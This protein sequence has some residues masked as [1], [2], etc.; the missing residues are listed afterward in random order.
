MGATAVGLTA[1]GS[2][3]TPS[4]YPIKHVVVIFQENNSFDHLLG[5]LCVDE[6]NRCDGTTVGKLSN[7]QSIPLKLGGDIVPAIAHEVNT[8]VT[9]IH[10]GAMDGWDKIPQ[11]TQA[12]GY[13]CL[14][15]DDRSRIPTLSALADQFVISDHTF[16]LYTPSSWGAHLDLVSADLAGFTGDNPDS[17][18]AG[19]LGWGCDSGGDAPWRNPNVPKAQVTPVPACIPNQQGQG[20]YRASPVTYVPTIM[21]RL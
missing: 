15:Q 14:E 11:C 21:D 16:Q 1:A 13:Q 18:F 19:A 10:G 4:S 7:G 6:D 17:G 8:M 2:G 12:A 20:P 9:A 3:P 5:K